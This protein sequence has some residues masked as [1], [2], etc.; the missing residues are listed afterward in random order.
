VKTDIGITH[1]VSHDQENVGTGR[2]RCSEEQRAC[3]EGKKKTAGEHRQGG[4]WEEEDSAD[5]YE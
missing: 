1:V 3:N 5:D 4:E 2:L